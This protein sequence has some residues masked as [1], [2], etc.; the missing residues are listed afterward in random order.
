VTQD[1]GRILA[2]VSNGDIRG[3][4]S[5]IENEQVNPYVRSAAMDGFADS[6]GLR[7]ARPGGNGTFISCSK[8]R[9]VR[10]ASLF[11]P[12]VGRYAAVLFDQ[13]HRRMARV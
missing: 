1:L 2:C 9:S 11:P 13:E 3:M 7:R 6:G 8:N 12:I 5:L 4:T 10:P